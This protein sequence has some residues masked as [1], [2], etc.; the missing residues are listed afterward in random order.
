MQYS[1][2]PDWAAKAGAWAGRYYERLRDRPV[3]SQVEPGDFLA[4]LPLAAPEEAEP[5]EKVFADF[6]AL[7]PDAMTHWQHPRFFAY[8][9]ANAAPAS[10]LAEQLISSLAC[11]CMLWQTSPARNRIG[12]THDRMVFAT[13]SGFRRILAD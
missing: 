12:G 6:E 9:P 2:L 3:R 5:M 11:N 1:D 10:I 13:R 4:R 8:F 7:V